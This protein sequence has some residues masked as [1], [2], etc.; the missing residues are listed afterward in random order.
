MKFK[1]GATAY[2]KAIGYGLTSYEKQE[3]ERVSKNKVFLCDLDTAYDAETGK[4]AGGSLGLE[5]R[6]CVTAADIKA[7]E[8]YVAEY[9]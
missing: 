2:T 9:G 6:L 5:I 4:G 1:K 8:A 7:A 3:V